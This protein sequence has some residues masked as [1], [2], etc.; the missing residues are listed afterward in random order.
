[1]SGFRDKRVHGAGRR[2]PGT[3][4]KISERARNTDAHERRNRAAVSFFGLRTSHFLFAGLKTLSAPIRA[5][6][7]T[8]LERVNTAFGQMVS[9]AFWSSA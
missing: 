7:S 6:P 5:S 1:M 3:R 4:L 2:G 8:T 9:A